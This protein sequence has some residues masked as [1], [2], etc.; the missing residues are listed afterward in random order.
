MMLPLAAGTPKHTKRYLQIRHLSVARDKRIGNIDG[1]RRYRERAARASEHRREDTSEE[2]SERP[3]SRLREA[4]DRKRTARHV[5]NIHARPWVSKTINPLASAWP[6]PASRRTRSTLVGTVGATLRCAD[7]LHQ[8]WWFSGTMLDDWGLRNAR[9]HSTVPSP[10]AGGFTASKF[11]AVL[12]S[13]LA[14]GIVDAA[15]FACNLAVGTVARHNQAW[16]WLAGLPCCA[17]CSAR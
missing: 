2:R 4:Q 7:L 8:G 9:H 14:E 11:R 3:M 12:D 6:R 16:I 1:W 17:S 13:T 10:E 15:V 5:L